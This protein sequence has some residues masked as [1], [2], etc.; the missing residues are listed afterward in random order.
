MT[1]G[2]IYRDLS[3]MNQKL[4]R[5]ER[6][7]VQIEHSG[8]ILCTSGCIMLNIDGT[9]YNIYANMIVVYL[10]H[11]L[12]QIKYKSSG[13]CGFMLEADFETVQPL[14][15][16]VS[17]IN[18]LLLIRKNPV[19][20]L[21]EQQIHSLT[22][23]VQLYYE[24]IR[25]QKR[26]S[27]TSKSVHLLQIRNLQ[28]ELLANC[29]LLEIVSFYTDTDDRKTRLDRTDEIMQKFIAMLYK[30]YKE[31]HEVVYYAEKQFVTTRYFSSIIKKRSG[32][33]PSWWIAN[34][35]LTEAKHLLRDTSMS[36]K[37]ISE[38][39]NFPTQSYFGKWF[40]KHT[41]ISPIEFK[42]S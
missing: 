38:R 3:N 23:Y 24:H 37:E 16:K 19:M 26:S 28:T 2:I 22:T 39:M 6:N 33:T 17:D 1:D 10:P 36:I 30:H 32:K 14:L 18:R 35:L 4:L 27:D 15:Y 11:S 7:P 21:E 12:F 9:D 34:A 25:K 13:L 5:T 8:M 20:T 41:G 29:V 40:K 42:N 31:E